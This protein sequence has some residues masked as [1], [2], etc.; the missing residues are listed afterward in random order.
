MTRVVVVP[1]GMQRAVVEIIGPGVL[2]VET[3][4]NAPEVNLAP[5]GLTGPVGSQG[6]KGDPGPP[7][8]D[9]V[10]DDGFF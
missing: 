7:G 3:V 1:S 4:A 5:R 10:T 8:R 2:R 9:A 6:G